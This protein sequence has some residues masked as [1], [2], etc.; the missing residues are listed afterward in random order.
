[1][2][3]NKK[4]EKNGKRTIKYQ[5]FSNEF[6]LL[7]HQIKDKID[8]LMITE[9]LVNESFSIVQFFINGFSSLFR[10]DRDRNGG[11]SL[12]YIREDIPPK[13]LSVENIIGTFFV[14]IDLRNKK[15]LIKC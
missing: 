8:I 6:D 12:L 14:E 15:W 2:S 3:S 11:S 7:T 4:F 5:F 13:L 10:I 9:L 1:M